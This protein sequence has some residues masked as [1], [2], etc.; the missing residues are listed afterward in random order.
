MRAARD[1]RDQPP[2]SPPLRADGLVATHTRASACE[3]ED[4]MRGA[5]A[6]CS[7]IYR[8]MVPSP[9]PPDRTDRSNRTS[10]TPLSQQHISPRFHLGSPQFHLGS[11]SVSPRFHIGSHRF[12]IGFASFSQRDRRSLTDIPMWIRISLS[13][14]RRDRCGRCGRCPPSEQSFVKCPSSEE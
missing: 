14:D 9:R 10:T 4:G 2:I 12:H 1:R 6:R 3:M 7:A 8:K 5:G 13:S 11:T